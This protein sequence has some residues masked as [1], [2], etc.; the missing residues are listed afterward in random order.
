MNL[1]INRNFSYLTCVGLL[2]V[3][4]VAVLTKFDGIGIVTVQVTP[5]GIQV[6]VKNSDTLCTIDQH[7]P[8]VQPKLPDQELAKYRILQIHNEV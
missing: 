1:L 7:V 2:T 6:V 8:E 4:V 3:L 5:D